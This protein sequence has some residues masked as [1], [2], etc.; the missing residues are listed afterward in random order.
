MNGDLTTWLNSTNEPKLGRLE[1]ASPL[2]RRANALGG[3]IDVVL[4]S[5]FS[6]KASASINQS[7]GG[8]VCDTEE[9]LITRCKFARSPASSCSESILT[10]STGGNVRNASADA[11]G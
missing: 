9:H 6:G 7:R 5:W 1:R 11:S 10:V 2:L 8:T 4:A 3:L